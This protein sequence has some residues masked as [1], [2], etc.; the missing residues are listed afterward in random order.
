M[1]HSSAW[2]DL[3]RHRDRLS[4]RH[5]RDLFADDPDRFTRFSLEAE[6]LLLD[7]S[8]QRVTEETLSLL[9]ALAREASV[10][11]WRRRM[12][13]GERINSTED[14]AVL[15]MALRMPRNT[16][17]S[18]EGQDIIPA[19]HETLD[20]MR[21]F[22][23]GVRDGH[24]RGATGKP[25]TDLVNI[26]IG[27]SDLGPLMVTEALR[28]YRAGGPGVR[29]VS[30]VDP[31]H[32]EA[33]LADLD[34]QTTLFV[35]ASKTFITQETLTNARAARRWL[36][37]G[38]GDDET[39]LAAHFVAVTASP[40]RAEAFGVSDCFAFW[41]WVGGR[42]SL[43]SA[44]GLPIAVAVGFEHFEALLAGAHAMDCHFLEA[45]DQA[46]LPL[47]LALLGIWNRDFLGAESHA[48]LPYAQDLHRLPAYL[49]QAE[50]ESNG[51][52]VG[53]DGAPVAVATAPI[54]WGEPGTNGQ[55]AFYQLLHQGSPLV[56]TDFI[57]VAEGG[58]GET[59]GETAGEEALL[60]NALAQS[61]A[62]AFGRDE[63]EAR[64][65]LEAE[66]LD[67][68]RLAA[69]LPHKVFP[70]N[71]PSSTIL[72]DRLTPY[73]LGQLVALYEHKIFCQGAIWGLNAFDQWGVELGKQL[74]RTIQPD[75][76]ADA[77][78]GRHDSSTEGL[79]ARIRGFRARG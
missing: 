75:L 36:A 55:H 9:Q 69:L 53:R 12:A 60:A 68:A 15:H 71:R 2:H 13:A 10:A 14:R 51:K 34:P 59:G 33:A 49:Q 37:A 27:G 45:P 41:D 18:L 70:G 5:L 44:V 6:G 21:A 46:N 25:I 11:E 48:V 3:E 31:A 63:A 1:T 35:V 29:F 8:K 42:F 79:L 22:A 19:V 39:A 28:R 40:E 17:L 32:L 78:G 58:R 50:M 65:A 77:Q 66:G 16:R 54:V 47:T 43:W 74:A 76:A 67:G 61:A 56:P 23:D 30:N 73:R 72:I 7:L 20:R 52:S 26:G 57:V 38:L 24:R 64:A 4:K 62:L